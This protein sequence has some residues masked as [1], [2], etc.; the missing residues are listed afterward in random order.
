LRMNVRIVLFLTKWSDNSPRYD[1]SYAIN[2]GDDEAPEVYSDTTKDDIF[3]SDNVD[4]LI[5]YLS[6]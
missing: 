5:A 6:Q 1:I 2:K 3:Q 4:D